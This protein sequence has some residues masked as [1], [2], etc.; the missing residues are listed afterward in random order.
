MEDHAKIPAATIDFLKMTSAPANI[1]GRRATR[2]LRPFLLVPKVLA[3]AAL[4]GG[5]LAAAAIWSARVRL[6]PASAVAGVNV[7]LLRVCLP[8]W[9]LSVAFGLLLFMQHP[10]EFARMRWM[11]VKLL[12]LALALPVSGWIAVRGLASLEAMARGDGSTLTGAA[13]SRHVTLGLGMLI[14]SAAVTIVL[15]R[16]KPRLGQNW[17]L[18]FPRPVPNEPSPASSAATPPPSESGRP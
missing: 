9:I 14:A 8:A 12:W 10:R 1:H 13:A 6:G 11:R 15:G 2:G 7:I 4:L 17:A 3:V 5:I 16:Q 18:A